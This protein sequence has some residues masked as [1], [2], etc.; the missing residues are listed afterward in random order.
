MRGNCGV[1]REDSVEGDYGVSG[2][3]WCHMSHL[4][5]RWDRW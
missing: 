5:G 2:G 3:G 4:L 1:G